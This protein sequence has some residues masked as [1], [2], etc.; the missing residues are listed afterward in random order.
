MIEAGDRNP[1]VSWNLLLDLTDADPARDA[2][3]DLALQS[4]EVAIAQVV[5]RQWFGALTLASRTPLLWD[6]C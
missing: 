2:L 1:F 5:P 3:R 6:I 4:A